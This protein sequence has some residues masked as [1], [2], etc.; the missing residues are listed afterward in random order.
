MVNRPDKAS[1]VIF[2]YLARIV[3]YKTIVEARE[4]MGEMTLK[5]PEAYR[6]RGSM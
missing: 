4:T 3:K 6:G 2:I 1:G 5:K